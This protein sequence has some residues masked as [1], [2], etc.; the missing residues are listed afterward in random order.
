MILHSHR[1]LYSFPSLSSRNM[2]YRKAS[3]HRIFESTNR[4]D[5]NQ[6]KS[7]QIDNKNHHLFLDNKQVELLALLLLLLDLADDGAEIF[8]VLVI[9]K[10]SHGY[11]SKNSS[12]VFLI[13]FSS[14]IACKRPLFQLAVCCM[15]GYKS[16]PRDWPI[17]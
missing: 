9:Q 15:V 3:R 5:S 6:T 14:Q 17:C 1:A 10:R 16:A 11:V 13:F 12:V 4:T 2:R 8:D 7:N